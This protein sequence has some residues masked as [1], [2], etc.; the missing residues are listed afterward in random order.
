M[1]CARAPLLTV[2][3]QNDQ[4]GLLIQSLSHGPLMI[5]SLVVFILHWP[6]SY[7]IQAFCRL[8][9]FP[10]HR[11]EKNHTFF[12]YLTHLLCE[13]EQEWVVHSRKGEK[14]FLWT[15]LFIWF[16]C[17][18]FHRSVNQII[19]TDAIVQLEEVSRIIS[20]FICFSCLR[21]FLC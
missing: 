15:K 12:T 9:M 11:R 14:R 17:I 1:V 7:T 16:I 20:D 21:R 2:W 10:S 13:C 8:Q 4:P 19:L 18:E 5:K 3:D 6:F